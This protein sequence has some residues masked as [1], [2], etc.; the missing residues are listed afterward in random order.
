M[1]VMKLDGEI[2]ECKEGW[3]NDENS[4]GNVQP[5]NAKSKSKS[6]QAAIAKGITHRQTNFGG[7]PCHEVKKLGEVGDGLN[8]ANCI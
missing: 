4:V 5:I 7:V 1:I 2:W 6:D 3:G 8:Y